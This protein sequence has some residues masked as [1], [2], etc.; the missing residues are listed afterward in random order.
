M[1][2]WILNIVIFLICLCIPIGVYAFL[3]SDE[4]NFELCFNIILGVFITILI[5]DITGFIVMSI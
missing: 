3:T 4:D 1:V 5:L 2:G